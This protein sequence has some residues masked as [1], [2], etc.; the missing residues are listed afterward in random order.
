MENLRPEGLGGK[1][2]PVE[3][4]PVPDQTSLKSNSLLWSLGIIRARASAGNGWCVKCWHQAEVKLASVLAQSISK[5]GPRLAGTC[6][7]EVHPAPRQW[8]WPVL[9]RPKHC[10]VTAVVACSSFWAPGPWAVGLWEVVFWGGKEASCWLEGSPG[11]LALPWTP[12]SI[13]GV[14]SS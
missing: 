4:G 10:K 6:L 3:K 13:W 11:F 7:M 14:F 9:R 1:K 2:L 12:G 5:W 8:C